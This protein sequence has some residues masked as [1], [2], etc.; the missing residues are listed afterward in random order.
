MAVQVQRYTFTVG[1]YHRM[2]EAGILTEDD[3]VE[4]ICGEITEMAPIGSRHANSA[5]G[6]NELLG[7]ALRGRAVVRV[8]NP[9]T[10]DEHSEPQPDIVLAH[11]PRGRY[12]GAH[13][14][15]GEVFLVVEVADTTLQFDR[16]VKLPLYAKAGIPEVWIVDLV[17]HRIET[18]R[19]PTPYGYREPRYR[20]PGETLSP[21]AFPD[22][23]LKVDDVLA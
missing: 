7:E 22:V 6:F 14:G 4:L 20:Y 1:D 23:I 21:S 10:I 16:E 9:I 8:Q 18:Y 11:P 19:D 3:R 12:A 2:A 15:P 5:D 13:P 17:G